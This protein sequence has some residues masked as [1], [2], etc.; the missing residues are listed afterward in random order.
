V[1]RGRGTRSQGRCG[2]RYPQHASVSSGGE[3]GTMEGKFCGGTEPCVHG[4]CVY[5]CSK[6]YQL[7]AES[8]VAGAER[9]K[10][11]VE[12]A[13]MAQDGGVHYL[14][15]GDSRNIISSNFPLSS[16]LSSRPLTD[17]QRHMTALMTGGM[18]LGVGKQTQRTVVAP[19]ICRTATVRTWP[20]V[21][22]DGGHKV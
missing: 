15:Y 9:E 18:M 16:L 1:T 21:T 6:Q 3:R 5:A 13:A 7:P 19:A 12:R 4:Q 10:E 22:Q 17:H 20:D 14:N 8:S 2:C 11:V